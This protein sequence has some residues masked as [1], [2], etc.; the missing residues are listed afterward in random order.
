MKTSLR[1]AAVALTVFIATTNAFTQEWTKAQ[2][3]VW[4][5]VEDGWTKWKTGDLASM[6]AYLHEKYQ[7]WNDQIPLPITKQQVKQSNLEM[8]DIMKLDHFSLNPA[9][10]VIT[11][12]AAVVDYY[13]MYEGTYTRGEKKELM[14]VHGQNV[15]FYIKEGGKWLLLGDMTTVKEKENHHEDHE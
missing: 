12:N 4:Q 9:R 14:E 15:E 3:E 7:G 5:I 11:E 2:N 13:Y 1:L 10:I 6:E 8:K